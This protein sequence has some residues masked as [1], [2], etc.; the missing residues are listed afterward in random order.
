M[1]VA[2]RQAKIKATLTVMMTVMWMVSP[3]KKA[4]PPMGQQALQQ[5][6]VKGNEN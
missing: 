6:C 1:I 4:L 5:A 2:S 3:L